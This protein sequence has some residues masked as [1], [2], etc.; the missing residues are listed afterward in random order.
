MEIKSTQGGNQILKKKK[1]SAEDSFDFQ[2]TLIFVSSLQMLSEEHKKIHLHK[3][4]LV[5]RTNN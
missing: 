4:S 5:L 1:K 2:R 3:L